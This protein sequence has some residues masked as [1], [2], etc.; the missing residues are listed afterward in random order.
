MSR[1]LAIQCGTLQM[2]Q[3]RDTYD[4]DVIERARQRGTPVTITAYVPECGEDRLFTIEGLNRARD[5][6]GVE[7][8]VGYIFEGST[9]AYVT[10]HNNPAEADPLNL[11]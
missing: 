4:M 6:W 3:V 9:V 11:R 1:L 5:G 2:L 10:F 8:T 7:H